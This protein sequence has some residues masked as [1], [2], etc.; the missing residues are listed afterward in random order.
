MSERTSHSSC[1]HR[2]YKL[3]C[4]DYDALMKRAEGRCEI[5]RIAAEDTPRGAL[6][7]DHDQ[8]YGHPAVRG[9]LC[10]KCNSLMSRIDR[11]LRWED[12]RA[13]RYIRRA[14]FAVF[15]EERMA[16]EGSR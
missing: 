5:C 7:I 13:N 15:F 3:T 11:G 14:W 4:A 9:L 2:T 16:R 12:A 8:R 6:V 10:D 1:H